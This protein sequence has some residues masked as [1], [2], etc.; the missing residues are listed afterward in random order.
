MNKRQ[1][2]Q[3]SLKTIA[4]ITML[5]DHVGAT[6]LPNIGLRCVGRIAFPIYCFLLAEGVHYTKDAKRYALRLGTGALL[7]EIPFDILFFGSVTLLHQSVMIT[8]LL[9]FFM[10]NLMKRAKLFWQKVLWILPFAL[11]AEWMRT[12]YGGMGIILIALFILTRNMP[13]QRLIQTAGMAI[14][15]CLMDSYLISFGWISI[16]I[17]LL[18]VFSMIPIAL[19]TGHKATSSRWIQWGFYLFYPLHLT[20]LLGIRLYIGA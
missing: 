7:S 3:E 8:L 13:Y 14:I 19:Y 15:C 5:L 1:L 18:A 16:P 20:M 12:D 9:G 6:F 2:S 4:C 10:A 17:E 11:T